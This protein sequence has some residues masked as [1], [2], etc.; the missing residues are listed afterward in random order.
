MILRVVLK[1][2]V[3]RLLQEFV[4]K[5]D[6]GLEVVYALSGWLKSSRR[7]YHIRLVSGPKLAG[8]C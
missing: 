4:E 5:H 2:V 7:S 6:G 8:T 3:Y 1:V